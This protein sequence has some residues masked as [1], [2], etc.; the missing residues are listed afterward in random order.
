MNDDVSSSY[1]LNRLDDVMTDMTHSTSLSLLDAVANLGREMGTETADALLADHPS[2]FDFAPRLEAAFYEY[3]V[4][5]E[6]NEIR[7]L[8]SMKL[9]GPVAF[10]DVMS[11]TV[12]NTYN[13][14]SDIFGWLDFTG[15]ERFVMVGCGQLP[16]SALHVH[17]R[18]NVGE[19]ICIDVRPDAVSDVDFLAGKLGMDNLR[20]TACDG[21]DFNYRGAQVVYVANMV[22]GKTAV[23]A[24]ILETAPEDVQIVVRSPAGLGRLWTEAL[25][26]VAMLGLQ[27]AERGHVGRNLARDHLLTAS[28]Q[29][30]S[31]LC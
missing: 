4:A 2:L 24:R 29:D 10:C 8:R 25:D 5:S 11:E 27:I 15:C 28:R 6:D 21:K 18:T 26:D 23:V 22:K 7:R 19:V 1:W 14:V 13:R 30:G 16:V 20:A 17:D 9:T 3:A 12:T 31:G